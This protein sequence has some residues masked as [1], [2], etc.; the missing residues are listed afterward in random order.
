MADTE[1]KD[2]TEAFLHEPKGIS[3]AISGSTYTANGAGSG[4]WVSPPG[5]LS[6]IVIINSLADL[7][8]PVASVITLAA[9][10]IYRFSGSVDIGANRF[11]ADA[12]TAFH[13]EDAFIDGIVSSTTGALITST[14]V[15]IALDSINLTV[16]SGSYFNFTGSVSLDAIRLETVFLLGCTTAG[17]ITNCSLFT[18]R[19]SFILPP[20][21]TGFVFSGT[22][23]GS[24]KVSNSTIN[25]GTTGIG[26]DFGSSVWASIFIGPDNTFNADAGG[27]S[28]DIAVASGNLIAAGQ[29]YIF[30]NIFSGAGTPIV[31]STEADIRWITGG[32]TGFIS[33]TYAAQGSI[34]NSALAT[35]FP[36]LTITNVVNV[37]F[38][39]AF[40]PDIVS[41]FTIDTA[42]K[43]TYIG[44]E[45][46][47]FFFDATLF[48]SIAGGATRQYVYAIAINGVVESGTISKAEYD[49]SN[50]GSNSVSGI[51]A[52]SQ[53]DFVELQVYAVTAVTDLVIDT[54]SIKI[55]T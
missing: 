40:V 20:A 49:G 47:T 41:Q 4:N 19:K 17:T 42:G 36:G 34:E 15:S 31:G 8:A 12:N 10:T 50:P 21:T 51:L 18:F 33:S 25:T 9:N 44:S 1:H 46:R 43:F 5:S 22:S 38:G 27:T 7:P 54:A 48:G 28:L 16:S 3:T 11:V 13:G 52:L 2:I 39:A 55:R 37:N 24:F 29:G 35:T 53:N 23:N 45:T 6:N 26:V 32:N 30:T 14:D